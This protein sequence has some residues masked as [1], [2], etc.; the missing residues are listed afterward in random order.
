MKDF[1]TESEIERI[2]ELEDVGDIPAWLLIQ[3]PKGQLCYIDLS[4]PD[5]FWNKGDKNND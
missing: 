4:E 1:F 2:N 3:E 5:I